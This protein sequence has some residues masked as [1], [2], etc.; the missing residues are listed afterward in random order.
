LHVGNLRTAWVSHLFARTWNEPWVVRFE[1]IDAPRSLP[2]AREEQ[3][4]DMA[5]L[6]LKPD[7]VVIQSALR[8]R[9]WETFSRAIREKRV[10]PCTCSRKEVREAL[11]RAG[12]APHPAR[13]AAAPTY[14]GHCRLEGPSNGHGLPSLAWRFAVVEDPSGRSDFIVGRSSIELDARGLPANLDSFA[15]AYHWACAVD[16][17]DGGYRLLV[18]AADLAEVLPQHRAIMRWLAESE[19][20]GGPGLPGVFHTSLVTQNDGHRLEKRT[21][22]A[23]LDELAA[24]GYPISRILERFAESWDADCFRARAPGECFGEKKETMTLKELGLS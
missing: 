13:G 21:K 14:S 2:G 6:G 15:P 17:L 16:D 1:D 12:S 10:Y 7:Q 9:H 23:T 20:R 19:H 4:A 18:R 3:L 11:E 24:N 8:A 5:A 22:G